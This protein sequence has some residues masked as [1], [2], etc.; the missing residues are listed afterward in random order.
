M[1]DETAPAT[2]A[3]PDDQ[4]NQI[5]RQL[6]SGQTARPAVDPNAG[7]S[8][9]EGRSVGSLLGEAVGGGA[10]YGSTS[11]REQGGYAALGALGARMLQASD[12]STMPH[13]FGSILGQGLE[14]ARGSLG[15]TQAVSAARQYAAQDYAHQAQQDQIA[16]LKE[17]LP[18]LNLQEQ[19]RAAERARELLKPE[20][21]TSIGTGGSI[22]TAGDYSVPADLLPIYKAEAERTGVP[23]ELLIAQHKQESNLNPGATGGAGEVGLGQILPSTAKS[24]GFGMA[25]VDPGALRTPAANIRFSADYL[26]ARAKAAGADF[27][28]PEGTVKALRAYNGGGDPNY[29]QNVLR[30][31]PGAQKALA[32]GAAPPA[33]A[34]APGQAAS[35]SPE[36]PLLTDGT[37]QTAGDVGAP[38]GTVIPPSPPGSEAT[39]AAIE[40]GRAASPTRGGGQPGAVVT[41]QAGGQPATAARYPPIP[42]AGGIVVAHPGSASEFHAR[43]Y[44]PPPQTEDYNPNLTARQQ[45]AFA[46]EGK[47]LDQRALVERAKTNPDL[48][49]VADIRAGREE[50]R[51]KVELAAQ[52][53]A[54][55]AAVARSAYDK[56][57][58]TRIDARY[59]KERA[60]YDAAAKAAQ[61]QTHEMEKI[62]R[63]A[64]ATRETEAAKQEGMVI[65]DERKDMAKARD[66]TRQ[67]IDQVHIL[68]ALSDRAGTATTIENITLP[69]GQTIRDLMVQN[70]LGSEATLKHLNAQQAYEAAATQMVFELRRGVQMGSLS[71]RDLLAVQ[72]L[73]PKGSVNPEARAAILGTIEQ[74]HSRQREY[75]DRV[76]QL[77]DQGKGLSWEKAKVEADK[78]MGD[79]VPQVPQSYKSMTA[80]QKLEWFRTNAPPH[81][82]L[83]TMDELDDNGK[84]VRR[85][86]IIQIPEAPQK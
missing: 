70:G 21:K 58:Y 1:A 8:S 71:D 83:R 27:K 56:E 52:E 17:A 14:A 33:S 64:A 37:A 76:H 26:A 66:A 36:P 81:T 68:R 60:A 80:E 24:P 82:L 86:H 63:T 41:A 84:I 77:W 9:R 28:T 62:D 34:P 40:E 73:V 85:G 51:A 39:V 54:Q 29:A 79:I 57:Q 44:A 61:T 19:R 49:V 47:A 7:P 65:V 42:I 20:N 59:E 22:G 2:P 13:T 30:Y 31:V 72:R 4:L 35:P 15:Q 38:T 5:I 45:A 55:K 6:L 11:D 43:E 67:S 3:I 18:Y 53:K 69:N 12:W 23:V 48:K 74:I 16:R 75:I 10:R 32:G 50:L 46:A 78:Q 25:G